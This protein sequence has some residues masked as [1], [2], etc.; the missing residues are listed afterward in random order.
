M[1]IKLVENL[2]DRLTPVLTALGHDVDSVMSEQLAEH[3]NDWTGCLVVAT[4]HKIRVKRP[5]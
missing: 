3:V 2:P 4:E 5:I 1:K